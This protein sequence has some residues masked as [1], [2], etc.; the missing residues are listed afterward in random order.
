M[1]TTRRRTVSTTLAE[2]GQSAAFA[3]YTRPAADGTQHIAETVTFPV[4]DVHADLLSTFALMGFATAWSNRFQRL[5]NPHASDVRRSFDEFVAIV[6]DGTWQPGRAIGEG[7]PT[8]LELAIAEATG[9]PV[10]VIQKR[11]EEDV[12]RTPDGQPVL[13][14]RG[15]HK[16]IF[17]KAYLE[18]IAND[19]KVKPIYARIVAERARRLAAEAKA[20][21][22]DTST[23]VDLFGSPAPQAAAD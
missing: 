18:A 12:V 14:A 6:K 17:T 20:D 21:K 19:P 16:R 2:D 7:E 8:D 5:D 10:H 22:R 11:I 15:R 4:A 23:V 3:I 1:A 9:Q 13:D